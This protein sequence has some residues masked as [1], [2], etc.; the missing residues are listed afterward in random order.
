[1]KYKLILFLL[2]ISSIT[3]I[4]QTAV[5]GSVVEAISGEPIPGVNVMIKNHKGKLIG[6]T[7]SSANG[8]FSLRLNAI[9]DSLIINATMLGYKPYFAPLKMNGIHINIQME[10]G[11]LQ[12]QEVVVKADRIRENGDT[13]TYNV[14]SFAQKQDRTIGDVLKRMPGIDV[15]DDG[16]IQYQGAA[17]NRFYIEGNDLLGGK[18]GIATNGISHDDIG[19][20][21]VMENHQPMQVLKGISF[22]DQAAINLKMKSRSKASVLMHGDLSGGWSQQPIGALWQGNILTML[23]RGNYQMLT[24]FKSNNTGINLSDQ[25]I[26]FTTDRSDEAL[27]GYIS[28]ETP[29]TPNLHKKRSYFNRSWMVS[30]S[31]LLKI[32]KGRE[33]KVQVDYNDD[34]VETQGSTNTIYFIESGDK[35][36]IE[37]KNSLAHS[38][39]L[40]GKFTYEINEKSYF[41]NNTLF[42][43][44]SWNDISLSTSGSISN[45]QNAS[46]PQYNVKNLLKVIKR[47][48]NNKLVTFTSCNEWNSLP[49]SL[50]VCGNGKNYGE[51]IKQHSFYSDEKASLGFILK[52]VLLS[53]EAGISGYFRN[54]NT[55]LWGI[56]NFSQ[57]DRE[58]LTT[59]YIRIFAAPKFEWSYKNFEL[60]LNLPVNLYSYFFSGG[61]KNRTELF[62]SPSLAARY[63]ISPRMSLILRGSARRSPASLHDIHESSILTDYRSFCT[64]INDYYTSSGQTVSATYSYRHAQNGIFMIAMGSYGWNN[65][66]F[67]TVQNILGD[68]IFHYYRSQPTL[69]KNAMALLNISKTLDFM[70]GTVGLKG[71]YRKVDNKILSQGVYT[72]YSNESYSLSPSANGNI[73]SIFNWNLTFTWDRTSLKISDMKRKNTDSFI[74]SGSMTLT[75][76]SFMT[77]TTGG[78]FYHNQIESGRFNDMWM[79]DTKLTF[80]ICKCLEVSA[81]VTNLFNKRSYNYIAY[82]TLSQIERINKLRGREFLISIY[83]KK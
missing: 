15:S 41:L 38:H 7:S 59:D 20:V 81:S 65:S 12:L 3:A 52:R 24:T 27:R 74:Y 10:E 39:A 43:D 11:S 78:E 68:Y 76:T 32:K 47:F 53:L 72:A 61:L 42:A 49:E 30:S 25:L 36:V 48:G 23:V 19:A 64:G 69:S 4:S 8:T 73:S 16:K 70:R 21:E 2:F 75:P 51:Q 82:G 14:G 80:N 77:W 71:N 45:T 6:F 29:A 63:R 18:Y 60:A 34:R 44:F 79:I 17:I 5:E 56:E 50:Q 13:I 1:M 54:L 57:V 35:V 9:K 22:S 46:M 28:L 37:D 55:D 83:L 67:G 66:K 58:E 40:T 33:L 62:I 26:D 31:H